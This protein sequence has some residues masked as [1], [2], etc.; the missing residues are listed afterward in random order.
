MN[1]NWREDYTRVEQAIR[2]L[3]DNY[4]R[5]PSLTEVAASVGLS[6]FHFQRLF[7]RWAGISPKRFLQY[8]TKEHAKRLLQE[9]G[10][11]LD[12]AYETGLSG[13]S[14]L[15]DLFITCEAVT[16]GE[17]KHMGNGVEIRYGFHD[18]PFGEYLLAVTNRGIC[19]LYFVTQEGRQSRLEELRRCWRM[20]NLVE[21]PAATQATSDQI[22]PDGERKEPLRLLVH[23]TNFQIKV[24]EALL[25][26]PVGRVV[27]Y[28]TIAAHIGHPAAVRAVGSAVGANPITYIIP[29]HR[30]I[31]KAGDFGYY[32]GGPLRKRALLGWELARSGEQMDRGQVD[33]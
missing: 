7:T 27:A 13:P 28:E 17:Y 11:V 6:E 30:V 21:D 4:R 24:W 12:A 31:H 15:H 18:S 25:R 23:G 1:T 33:R 14:R 19:G 26:I 16:P 32:G 10:D 3:E 8:L 22:F 5:Q 2:F 9:S 20:A 29:C